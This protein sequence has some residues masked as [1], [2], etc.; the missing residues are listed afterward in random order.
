MTTDPTTAIIITPVI[1][2]VAKRILGPTADYIGEGLKD[3]AVKRTNNLEKI[4]TKTAAR[5]GDRIEQPGAIPPRVLKGVLQEG[6]FCDDELSA[7]YFGGI[8]A[9]SRSEVSRDDRGAMLI[10]LLSRLSTYQIRA[11]YIFYSLFKALFDGESLMPTLGADRRK[12]RIF[13]PFTVFDQ[14]MGFSDNEEPSAILENT[15][16]NLVK[17]NLIGGQFAYGDTD[18][19]RK[20]WKAADA[21][22]IVLEPSVFGIELFMWAYGAGNLPVRMYL[23]SDLKF[24]PIE[25][26]LIPPG[27]RRTG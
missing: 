3:W 6:S 13:V 25:G 26:I 1:S 16:F 18:H 20:S 24:P 21:S 2:D 19:L 17:E 11:H 4:F 9:S 7:E 5:L 10:S 14:G 22:G 8:L 27:S 23:N 15:I 12:M